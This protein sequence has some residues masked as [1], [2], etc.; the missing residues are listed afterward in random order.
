[1]GIE[2]AKS[3]LLLLLRIARERPSGVIFAACCLFVAAVSVHDAMLVVLNR[4]DIAEL[5][6]NPVGRWLI[7]LQGGEVWLFVLVK[8]AG[9]AVVCAVVVTLYEFRARLA[10]VASGGVAAF[11]MILLWYLTFAT[12]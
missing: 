11:Q 12:H 8:L 10:L 4:A 7:E 5:E 1:V 9:T 6:R 3:R 2:A